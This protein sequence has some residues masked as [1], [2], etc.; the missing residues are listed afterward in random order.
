M[1]NKLILLALMFL[2]VLSSITSSNQTL[3]S[4]RTVVSNVQYNLKFGFSGDAIAQDS[5][6]NVEVSNNFILSSVSSCSAR[7]STGASL[8]SA[9][10]TC[11]VNTIANGYNIALSGIFPSAVASLTY[12]EIQVSID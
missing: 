10:I 12:L 4:N 7:T 11:A 1:M 2:Y 6:A 9:G 5:T 3:S 8:S